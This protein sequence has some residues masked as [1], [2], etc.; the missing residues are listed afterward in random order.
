[1][2]CVGWPGCSAGFDAI[3]NRLR[4]VTHVRQIGAAYAQLIPLKD[5]VQTAEDLIRAD[6]TALLCPQ[7]DCARCNAVRAA[8]KNL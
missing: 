6:P 2:E 1:V 5:L 8:N 4:T 3:A 7:P